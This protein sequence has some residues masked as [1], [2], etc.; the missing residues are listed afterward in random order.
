LKAHAAVDP[1]SEIITI[2]VVMPGNAGD[3]S[4]AE[5]LIS[6]LLVGDDTG[7]DD[8][9]E[10]AATADVDENDEDV[11]TVYGDNTYG[12]GAFQESR[13]GAGIDSRCKKT[14]TAAQPSI[15]QSRPS[16]MHSNLTAHRCNTKSSRPGRDQIRRSNR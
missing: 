13:D 14:P 7:H 8:L 3:A 4:V 16:T 10:H 9:D 6:D 12:T 1:D 5:D 2:T 11:T 15:S